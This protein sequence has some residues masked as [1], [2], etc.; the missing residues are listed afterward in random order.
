M[1]RKAKKNK[2]KKKNKKRENVSDPHLHQPHQEPPNIG[3]IEQKELKPLLETGR[4][5]ET[6]TK[7]QNPNSRGNKRAVSKKGG[8]GECTLVPVWCRGSSRNIRMHPRS[9]FWYGGTSEC[10]LVPVFRSGGTSAKPPF[11]KTTLLRTPDF[12]LGN[13]QKR[14]TET[15]N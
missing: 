1:R 9:G 12:F 11:W 6:E 7:N 3:K 13:Q 8:F 4:K 14:E 5:R 2:M 10:T 15:K